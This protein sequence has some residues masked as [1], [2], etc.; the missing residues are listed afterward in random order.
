MRKKF[1]FKKLFSK[2]MLILIG[3]YVVMTLISQQKKINAYDSN[4]D[5]LSTTIEEKSEY[6]AELTATKDNI[7]SPE[8]IESVAREKLNMYMPNEKVYIDIGN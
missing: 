7:N 1:D 4:I 5:Y 2:L 3:I 8:Y 6:K